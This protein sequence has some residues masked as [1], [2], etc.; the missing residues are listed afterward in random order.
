MNIFFQYK[1]RYLIFKSQMATF[2][3]INNTNTSFSSS[4]ILVFIIQLKKYY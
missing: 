1:S 4:E 3:S 2:L